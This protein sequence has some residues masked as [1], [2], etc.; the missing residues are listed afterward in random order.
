MPLTK[1]EVL[2]KMK[3]PSV[4]LVN[5]LPQEDFDRL[6]IKGS[7]N[8]VFGRNVRSFE[9]AA[10]RKFSKDSFLITYG[11]DEKGTLDLNAAKLL[12]AHGFQAN[13]YPGGLKDWAQA[14]LPTSTTKHPSTDSAPADRRRTDGSRKKAS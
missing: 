4:V 7:Q 9:S 5:V 13:N 14:G 3:D 10:A 8:L 2:E 12:V 1:E 11:A 6:H